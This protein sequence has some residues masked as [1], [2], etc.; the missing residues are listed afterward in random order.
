MI[1]LD[2]YIFIKSSVSDALSSVSFGYT[3]IY[4]KR[5]VHIKHPPIGACLSDLQFME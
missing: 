5:A 4:E 2:I 3:G 1:G